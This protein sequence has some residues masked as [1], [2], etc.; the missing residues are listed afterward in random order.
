MAT[1]RR[2]P[3]GDEGHNTTKQIK[4]D[5]TAIYEKTLRILMSGEMKK[6]NLNDNSSQT[7]KGATGICFACNKKSQNIVQ[8]TYCTNK[9]CD[10]CSRQCDKCLDIFCRFCSSLNYDERFDRVFCLSCNED[11]KKIRSL[12]LQ[13]QQQLQQQQPHLH[14]H[15]Q[16][17][18]L[19]S[20]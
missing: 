14:P 9:T 5:M 6:M 1:K 11:E 4:N 12:C 18:T 19:S 13:Q 17:L 3:F 16:T 7:G 20:T 15:P 2:N 8:C 10:L